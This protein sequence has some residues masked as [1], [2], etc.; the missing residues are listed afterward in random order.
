MKYTERA[1][2]YGISVAD[3]AFK[4]FQEHPEYK[5]QGF[6]WADAGQ[7]MAKIG[8][9]GFYSSFK[10]IPKNLDALKAIVHETVLQRW[11]ELMK[12]NNL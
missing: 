9:A 11:A 7:S 5:G 4:D 6:T 1:R 10:K 3:N 8:A 12:E 2:L